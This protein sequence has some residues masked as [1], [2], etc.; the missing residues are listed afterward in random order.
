MFVFKILAAFSNST[1]SEK[2]TLTK[3]KSGVILIFQTDAK[4]NCHFSYSRNENQSILVPRGRD[5]KHPEKLNT[6]E[7]HA[8]HDF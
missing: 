3:S 1:M 4:G 2:T 5:K 6:T 7:L 8:L